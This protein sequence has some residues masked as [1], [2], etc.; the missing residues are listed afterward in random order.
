MPTNPAAAACEVTG[1]TKTEVLALVAEL[2]PHEHSDAVMLRWLE[3]LEQKIACEIHR[4]MPDGTLSTGSMGEQLAVPA[5]Y[6]R[7]YWT[8]LV[9]MLDFVSG[10]LELFDRSN[11][12]FGEAY[13]DY[14]R[15]VQRQ[16]NLAKH[17]RAR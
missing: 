16:G 12:L 14:A 6:D 1:M 15:F 7:V 11:K 2:K 13:G 17:R 8:Y 5:P 3:E 10:N 4:K 9:A